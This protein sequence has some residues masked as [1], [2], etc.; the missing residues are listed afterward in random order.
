MKRIK[1]T[2]RLHPKVVEGLEKAAIKE[3]RTQSKVAERA[4]AK[5][6]KVKI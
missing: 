3:D 5:Q 6:L 2:F 1:K 4:L